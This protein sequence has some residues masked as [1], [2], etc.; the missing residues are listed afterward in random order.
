M[1]GMKRILVVSDLHVGSTHAIMPPVVEL[2]PTATRY[3]RTVHAS[4]MQCEFYDAWSAMVTDAGKVDACFVLGDC[5]EGV[6]HKSEGYGVW[7]TDRS[8]QVR[9]AAD[10]LSMIKTRRYFG[11]QG[12]RYHVDANTTADLMVMDL[13]R[14]EFGT[15]LVVDVEDARIHL[16]HAIGHAR[17]PVSK[18]TAPTAEIALAALN[19]STYGEFALLLRGHRHD[20]YDIRNEF[21]HIAGCP[22]WK[23]RDTFAATHGTGMPAKCI[24]GLLLTVKGAECLIE[25]LTTRLAPKHQFR[26]VAL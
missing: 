26:E 18:S 24:G 4:E 7:T 21:G 19:A 12:S 16:N 8:A 3:A 25:P 2:G 13:L 20:L 15:D 1:V 9:V 22:S 6:D 10:L 17:S 5:V 23:A 14:G 11:V